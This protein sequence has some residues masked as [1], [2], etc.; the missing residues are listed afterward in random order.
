M[1]KKIKRYQALIGV[2]MFMALTTGSKTWAVDHTPWWNDSTTLRYGTNGL[3]GETTQSQYVNEIESGSYWYCRLGNLLDNDAGAIIGNV[4]L[5]FNDLTE[6]VGGPYSDGNQDTPAFGRL[7]MYHYFTTSGGLGHVNFANYNTTWTEPSSGNKGKVEIPGQDGSFFELYRYFTFGSSQLTGV[8]QSN[9]KYIILIHGWNPA[10]ISDAYAQV[11]D[12]GHPERDNFYVLYTRLQ[13]TLQGSDWKVLQYHM[14]K[15]TDTGDNDWWDVSFFPVRGTRAAEIARLHGYYLA[16]RLL[17]LCPNLEEIQFIAHSAGAWAA[18]SAVQY[19]LDNSS[20]LVQMTLLDPYIPGEN[21]II[22][23]NSNLVRAEMDEVDS[24]TNVNRIYRLEN[25]YAHDFATGTQETFDW[26]NYQN[27][28]PI[29]LRVDTLGHDEWDAH[30][31]PIRYYA[32]TILDPDQY[33]GWIRSMAYVEAPEGPPTMLDVT[34]ADNAKADVTWQRS[35]NTPLYQTA[36]AFDLYTE[37]WVDDFSDHG[38]WY[39]FNGTDE[40]GQ[41]NLGRSGAYH[42]WI[43]SSYTSGGFYSCNNPWTGIISSGTPHKPVNVTAENLGSRQVRL[44]WKTDYYGTWF[45]WLLAYKDD[46]P[47]KGWVQSQGPNGNAYWHYTGYGA[48][49]ATLTMPYD[50][51]YVVYLYANS[52]PPYV[53]SWGEK[54]EP[55]MQFVSTWTGEDNEWRIVTSWAVNHDND[56]HLKLPD[57]THIYYSNKGSLTSF[58]WAQLDLD[59]TTSTGPETITISQLQSGT[60]KFY[61]CDFTNRNNSS[62]TWLSNSSGCLVRVYL[63]ENLVGTW[64]IP[65]GRTG[66]YWHVFNIVNGVVQEINNVQ[67]S[68]P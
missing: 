48:S 66:P 27:Q 23:P 15:D 29:Q 31:G 28:I 47:F 18:R 7:F 49:E 63:G 62:S 52:W 46:E 2:I 33:G 42:V 50:G 3:P 12:S 38:M 26:G 19:V 45:Y 51:D 22:Q 8:T 35:T 55:A 37:E 16:E 10:G 32:D 17:E 20:A 58:P 14:E 68:A 34:D 30:G 53:G 9:T 41:I 64:N 39:L 24:F 40:S 1:M 65:T 6:P 11:G 25:Y 36:C 54:G 56:A 44:R 60:N 13:S 43:N 61:V 21:N 5:K 59:D 67:T 57:G 4:T